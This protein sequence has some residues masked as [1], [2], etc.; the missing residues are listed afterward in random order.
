LLSGVVGY[1]DFLGVGLS[2]HLYKKN[3]AGEAGPIKQLGIKI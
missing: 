1:D 2:A 3:G